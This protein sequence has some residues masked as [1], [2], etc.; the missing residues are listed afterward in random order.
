MKTLQECQKKT[1]ALSQE[2]IASSLTQ[3][4]EY[5]GNNKTKSNNG[6]TVPYD[7][8]ITLKILLII[9]SWDKRIVDLAREIGI[10]FKVLN[11]WTSKYWME[12]T[13]NSGKDFIPEYS[14][15]NDPEKHPKSTN[16]QDYGTLKGI[17]NIQWVCR[18]FDLKSNELCVGDIIF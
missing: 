5:I 8:A 11:Y 9:G 16:E 13:K 4:K 17:R 18:T 10:S 15:I 3:V 6:F 1:T 12:S 2:D 7:R 14:S